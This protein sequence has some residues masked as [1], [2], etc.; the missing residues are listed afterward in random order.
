MLIIYE[1]KLCVLY[2]LEYKCI[3]ILIN[4]YIRVL[5]NSVCD[6]TS[7]RTEVVVY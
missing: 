3:Y 6:R 7:G 4:I 5:A 2:S 1:R